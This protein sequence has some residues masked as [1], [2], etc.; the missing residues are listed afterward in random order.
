MDRL[1]WSSTT[2]VFVLQCF[3]PPPETPHASDP[4]DTISRH[5]KGRNLAIDETGVPIQLSDFFQQCFKKTR[6]PTSNVLMSKNPCVQESQLGHWNNL[7]RIYLDQTEQRY[8]LHF[9]KMGRMDKAA[10]IG[11]RL[12]EQDLLIKIQGGA[13]YEERLYLRSSESESAKREEWRPLVSPPAGTRYSEDNDEG[14]P[15]EEKR[16]ERPWCGLLRGRRERSVCSTCT[17]GSDAAVVADCKLAVS[18]HRV[19]A[20]P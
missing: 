20:V 11:P 4:R 15:E 7:Q 14:D 9:W 5:W 8:I 2:R 13:C 12:L 6:N 1:S 16:D 18:H 10:R 19:R 17:T 3:V